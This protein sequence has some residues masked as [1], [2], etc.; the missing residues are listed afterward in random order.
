M[1]LIL[2]VTVLA[3]G[4]GAKGADYELYLFAGQSNMDGRGKAANLTEAQRRPSE[5]TIIFYRNPPYASDGWQALAPGFSI[6]PKH[7]SGIP[8]PTF[9]PEI[10]FA[11]AMEKSQSDRR[12]AFI[13]GSKGGTSL[14]R[15]WQP[16]VKGDPKSQGPI[17]RNFVETVLL[18]TSAL[19]KDGHTFKLRGL[20]W[21]QGESDSKSGAETYHRRF[22]AFAERVREDLKAPMLPIVVGEVFD[23]GKRDGVRKA[24]RQFGEEDPAGGFVSSAGTTTWDPGT[25][26]DAKSQLLLGSRYAETMLKLT[27]EKPEA[28]WVNLFAGDSLEL[29][30]PG[31]TK[32]KNPSKELGDRWSLKDGVLHLDR[33][34]KSGRGGQIWTQKNYYDFELKFEFNIAYDGNSGVKYR[35]ADVDGSA[36]GC[37]YQIIDDDNYRDNKNPTHR[38]ACLYELV[39]VPKDRKWNPAGD[40]NSGRI[41]VSKNR[42]EHWLNDEKV[43]SIEFG[44][45]DWKQRFAKS[46]YKIHPDFSKN[47]GPIV[48]TDHQ[49]SVSYRNVYIRE[50][51]TRTDQSSVAEQKRKVAFPIS[52]P[53]TGYSHGREVALVEREDGLLIK[54][55]SEYEKARA[56]T[57]EYRK[58]TFFERLPEKYRKLDTQVPYPATE[59]MFKQEDI[60][61]AKWGKRALLLDVYGPEAKPDGRLPVVIVVHGG[62]WGK[63]SHKNYRSLAIN[64]AKRGFFT[65][66]VE[67]RLSGEAPLPA[68]IYD[69]KACVRWTRAN[70]DKYPFDPNA[71]GIT[72]GSAGGHL[73]AITA[74]T[75]DDL[76]FEGT[77][78]HLEYSS[79]INAVL[80]FYGPFRWIF[81]KALGTR[82]EG[83][84]TGND[85]YPDHH[86]RQGAKFP[87]LLCINEAYG[88]ESHENWGES[89]VQWIKENKAGEA[90]FFILDAPHGF[91]NFSPFQEKAIDHAE[92]FFRRVFEYQK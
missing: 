77:A 44:S 7:R 37:E 88:R 30:E 39:A 64:L 24:L 8:S 27:A 57:E 76:R 90:D 20:L 55:P 71:I 29:W 61:Y 21:H 33:D 19:I 31:P 83:R 54:A 26:F 73:S 91:L 1:K 59:G 32:A 5:K 89:T 36:I 14:R 70:A 87:P 66:A 15:D 80:S 79:E 67:Y 9:G 40:W 17:Y 68:A 75:N 86:I 3:M 16:G 50:L 28:G 85:V 92:K 43:V 84:I 22:V 78:N 58:T 38:T 35:A 63:G 51:N 42:F 47:A 62:G 11:A 72:G 52:K 41:R 49:D 81:S 18:A 13:K 6:P 25:H 10:G 48:L 45:E 46:K 65:I 60:V 2:A 53:I 12:F 74:V 4:A 34:A 23:N 56:E 82:I 69:L